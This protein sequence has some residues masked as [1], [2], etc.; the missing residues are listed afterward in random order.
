[1]Q[2]VYDRSDKKVN[3]LYDTGRRWSLQYFEEIYKRLGTKFDYYYFESDAAKAGKKIVEQGIKKGIFKKSQ[4]AVVFPGEKHGLHT[5][6]FINSVGLPTYEAKELGLA[7]TK[8]KD[9]AYDLS[10]IITGNEIIDY[11]KVLLTALA[12][13]NPSIAE[14]TKHLSHGMVRLPEGKM[15]SRTGN[16]VTAEQLIGEVKKRALHIMESSRSD[17]PKAQ[18]QATAEI[19]AVGAIKYSLLRVGLGKDIIFDFDKSLSL[20][21]ESGPYLQ[22]TY[23]RCRSILRQVNLAKLSFPKLSL[24]KF[25][26]EEEKLLRL[27][28]RLPEVVESAAQNFSPNLVAS[29]VFDVAQAYNN[30]YNTHRVLQAETKEVK[31]FRLLLTG[32][33]AQIIQNSLY[34]LGMK[35]PERM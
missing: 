15:S 14:K 18:Q 12:K 29:F 9:F 25:S 13:I 17:I 28:Y 5:R 21:G 16:I 23:A 33:V 6:V 31:H 35:T 24:A 8:Y 7:P 34:L 2:A 30:F 20:E 10:L 3:K 4:G 1:M 19:I 11:F 26:K 27:L 22:Y 32:A